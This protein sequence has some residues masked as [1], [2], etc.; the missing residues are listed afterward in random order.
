MSTT[1]SSFIAAEA[2]YEKHEGVFSRIAQVFY[3]EHGI[4]VEITACAIKQRLN[5]AL[6]QELPS[7][8]LKSACSSL[9]SFISFYSVIIYLLILGVLGKR[10]QSF[11]FDVLFDYFDDCADDF[12]SE[13]IDKLPTLR[14][15][16]IAPKRSNINKTRLASF[17]K[18]L[19]RP[20]GQITRNAARQVARSHV[21]KYSLYRSLERNQG[22]AITDLVLRLI[23][24]LVTHLS[25]TEGLKT[26][27]LVSAED[28]GYS[29]LRYH[30]YKKQSVDQLLLIQNGCRV[31]LSAFYN[32][33]IHCDTYFGWLADRNNQFLGMV[34]SNKLVVGSTRLSNFL[35][36]Q[37]PIASTANY[38]AVFFE[39]ILIHGHPKY[40]VYMSIIKN[41]VQFSND[42]PHLRIAY[43]YR[44][45]RDIPVQNLSTCNAIDQIVRNG[46]LILL[47]A[48][49]ENDSSYSDLL[50]TNLVVGMDSSMRCEALI[51]G[52]SVVSCSDR[53]ETNDYVVNGCKQNFIIDSIEYQRFSEILGDAIDI[54]GVRPLNNPLGEMPDPSLIIVR[55]ILELT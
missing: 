19:L 42:N 5:G 3:A 45:F 24:E 28:N 54:T 7:Q 6:S 4:P 26:K 11:T 43:R 10:H 21:F 36:I 38:D 27:V 52:K 14:V 18:I 47:G 33:Y 25:A 55:H 8:W 12:Y 46:A 20:K 50:N 30:L 40:A 51:L 53:V 23:L 39:Q 22:I 37:E 29:P 13:I 35:K 31:E 44:K 41:L 49:P 17:S 1:N 2:L 15:G 9:Y 16:A 32:C 34:C 48:G